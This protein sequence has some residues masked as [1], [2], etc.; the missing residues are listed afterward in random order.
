[1]EN[2]LKLLIN[3]LR[4]LFQAL[5]SLRFENN[6]SLDNDN[7]DN[8]ITK[9]EGHPSMVAIN[10][11]MKRFNKTFTFQN[12]STDKVASIIKY[13]KTNSNTKKVSKSDETPAK[14]TKEFGTCFVEFLSKNFN[15]RHYPRRLKYA[16]VVHIY[17]KNDK[18]DKG[19][20]RPISLPS[21]ISKVYE[22]CMYEQ[23]EEYFMDY[24]QNISAVL[25]KV[26]RLRIVFWL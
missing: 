8:R 19:H 3:I 13:K 15:S 23:I 25:G 20:Y 22:R 7:I 16:E 24:Y 14:I 9:F 18:K 5:V 10:E 11:Q 12:I 17:K 1:M 6:D 26:V 2:L 4:I 21:N